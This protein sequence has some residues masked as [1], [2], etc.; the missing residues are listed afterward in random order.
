MGD[1]SVIPILPTLQECNIITVM[2]PGLRQNQSLDQ[3]H[4]VART[5]DRR[6]EKMDKPFSRNTSCSSL[7]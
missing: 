2:L 1:F 4:L 6:A 5:I 3:L 7:S